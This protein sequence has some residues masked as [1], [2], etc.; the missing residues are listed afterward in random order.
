ME[1]RLG[2]LEI[3]WRLGGERLVS[4]QER[5]LTSWFGLALDAP[6]SC[7]APES[8]D[9]LAYLQRL[10]ALS[11]ADA[12]TMERC[13]VTALT[14]RGHSERAVA[15]AIREGGVDGV[16]AALAEQNAEAAAWQ[17]QERERDGWWSPMRNT[18]ERSE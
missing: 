15:E 14:E 3:L 4:R 16:L 1:R 2:R 12:A 13:L 18:H 10:I 6:A 9:H 17:Q 11:R 5:E 7:A 8:A